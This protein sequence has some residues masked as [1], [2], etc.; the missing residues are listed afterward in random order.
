[1]KQKI[2]A[3]NFDHDNNKVIIEFKRK[4]DSK[5]YGFPQLVNFLNKFFNKK[6]L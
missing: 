5:G 2:I 4:L 6:Y 3:I 1:M